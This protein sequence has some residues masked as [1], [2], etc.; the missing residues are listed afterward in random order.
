V[1]SAGPLPLSMAVNFCR[2]LGGFGAN[3][4]MPL[5]SKGSLLSVAGSGNG[6]TGI[7]LHGAASCI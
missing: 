1:V 4:I 7:C 3:L 6:F 5:I 2:G